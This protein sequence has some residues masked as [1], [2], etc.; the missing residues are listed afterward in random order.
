MNPNFVEIGR[1][2]IR[3]CGKANKKAGIFLREGNKTSYIII[4]RPAFVPS[5]LVPKFMTIRQGV[6]P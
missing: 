2:I 5:T 3:N 6:W 4:C 1:G